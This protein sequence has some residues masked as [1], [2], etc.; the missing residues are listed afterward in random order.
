MLGRL[1]GGGVVWDN[2]AFLPQ[3]AR[4]REA[5]IDVVTLNVAFGNQ[6]C[7]SAL[8]MLEA[9]RGWLDAR[10]D[11]YLL[12]ENANNAEA[13]RDTQRLGVCFDNLLAF[14]PARPVGSPAEHPGR[15]HESVRG[16]R[17]RDRPQWIRPL[18]GAQ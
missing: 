2:H 16:T 15:S 13:V 14:E 8:A 1:T 7:Q 11:A 3:L 4:I 10:P 5:G 6:G 17:R 12:V 9:F 18:S